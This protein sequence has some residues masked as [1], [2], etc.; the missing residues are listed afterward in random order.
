MIRLHHE[1]PLVSN[2]KYAEIVGLWIKM[3]STLFK[4][5]KDVHMT[6][7]AP[8]YNCPQEVSSKNKL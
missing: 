4:K 7:L 6:W 3:R 8:E 2:N 5:K 1:N